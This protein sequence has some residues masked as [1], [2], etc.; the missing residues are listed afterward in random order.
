MTQVILNNSYAIKYHQ[1]PNHD[2]SVSKHTMQLK[3]IKFQI[4]T[5]V[6][7]KT[8][9]QLSLTKFQIMTQ[10]I[11]KRSYALNLTKFQVMTRV[12]QN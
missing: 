12:I 3:L 4:V 10:V 11:Q 7:Q 6:I 9:M 8:A 2:T 5:Q 1:I